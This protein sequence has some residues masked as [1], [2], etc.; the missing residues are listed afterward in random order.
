MSRLSWLIL[1]FLFWSCT[2]E[3]PSAE[4]KFSDLKISKTGLTYAVVEA[5]MIQPGNSPII[6][7]G[8]C[9]SSSTT[10]PTIDS[11]GFMVSHQNTANF[12]DTIKGIA[13][14]TKYYLRSFAK[15][16]TGVYY[17]NTDSFTTQNS[18][19]QLGQ[20]YQGGY[21]FY[22]DSTGEHGL[23]ACKSYGHCTWT[24]WLDG[25]NYV[26]IGTGSKLG[27]GQSNTRAIIQ[28]GVTHPTTAAKYCDDLVYGGFDDWFL[29]S[30]EELWTL[31][32]N[33][34]QEWA[35]TNLL[36][37]GD[38]YWSSSEVDFVDYP[39][40]AKIVVLNGSADFS[41]DNKQY[42][43]GVIPVRKF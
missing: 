43:H 42:D 12:S 24:Y 22:I 25:M 7:Q 6:Q 2:K 14:N 33:L 4:V 11:S 26:H 41:S 5:T 35:I 17:S 23:I 31:R 3:K 32:A 37:P 38:I 15:T 36:Y 40:V 20:N 13:F 30:S 27:M 8:F 21:I 34:H 29:P 10:K 9:W 1:P 19:Y 28:A 39:H 16:G 18:P